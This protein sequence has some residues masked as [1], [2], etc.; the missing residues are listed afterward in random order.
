MAWTDTEIHNAWKTQR[1]APPQER[2]EMRQGL[3]QTFYDPSLTRKMADALPQGAAASQEFLQV[4]EK[5]IRQNRRE[6]TIRVDQSGGGRKSMYVDPNRVWMDVAGL[7][8]RRGQIPPQV[9]RQMRRDDPILLSIIQNLKNRAQAFAK[10]VAQGLAVMLRGVEGF[11]FR[12]KYKGDHEPLTPHEERLR[13]RF[14]D[15]L[16]NGG[17]APRFTSDGSPNREDLE[18][19]T[20]SQNFGLIIDQRYTFDGVPI[21]LERTRDGRSLSGF[22]VL[23]GDTIHRIDA[24]QWSRMNNLVAQE[25]PNAKFAQAI[26]D[27]IY[28]TYG[29]N[30]LYYDYVNAQDGLGMRGYGLSEVEMCARLTIGVMNVMTHTSSLFDRNAI[31]NSI[32]V[33]KGMINDSVLTEFGESWSGYRLGAGGDYMFPILNFRDPAS[34][35]ELLN[36]QNQPQDM[37]FTQFLS[38]LGAI[39]CSVFGIDASEINLSAFGGNNAG[40]SSGK[41]TDVK[42]NDSRNRAFL[43]MMMRLEHLFNTILQ[44]LIGD[45]WEFKFIGLAKMEIETMRELVE[46]SVTVNEARTGILGMAPMDDSLVG[47]SLLNNPGISQMKIAAVGNKVI[48][49]D[50]NGIP[51]NRE[52]AQKKGGKGKKG[53]TATELE[54]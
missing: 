16:M 22:Y 52:P 8:P 18:R 42:L 43:P 20:L 11:D 38:F 44:P 3:T 40:L 29:S 54:D 19:E 48:D 30:D 24:A 32:M 4:V 41:D 17:D 31:P 26:Q 28:T 27:T 9:L 6:H 39:D 5:A 51:D 33:L 34:S 36:V 45:D 13:R 46:K 23:P 10:P 35:A 53:I 25:N 37:A 14:I 21:E 47:D 15:F 7:R 12:P 50:G 49:K 2:R 1:Y